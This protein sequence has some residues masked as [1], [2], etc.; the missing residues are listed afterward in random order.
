MRVEILTVGPLA[1]CC[2][3]VICP[4]TQKA[5]IIDP[6]GDEDLILGK[7]KSLGLKVSYILATHGHADHVCGAWRLRRELDAPLAMHKDDDEFFR[8]PEAMAIFSAWGFEPNEP[9]DLTFEDGEVFSI[10]KIHLKVIHT[11][12]HSPGSVCFYDEERY[13]FTGDTLFVGAV[14][15]SDL[16]GGNFQEMLRSIEKK[17]LVLPD[18]TIILPGHDYGDRPYSTIG[19]EKKTNP[20][21][22]EFILGG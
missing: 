10:G 6:G 11:P 14:G 15:R 5:A 20:Y 3:F 19:Q 16:P 17:L 21:I 13:I 22:T 7:I 1:V 8:T 12:G 9:A 4:A 18:E 2:Y